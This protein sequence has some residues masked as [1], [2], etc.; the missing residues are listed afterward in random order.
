MPRNA[1]RHASW[2]SWFKLCGV[3]ASAPIQ[4]IWMDADDL[5]QTLI[6]ISRFLHSF[7][8]R[9]Q[10]LALTQHGKVI[11]HQFGRHVKHYRHLAGRHPLLLRQQPMGYV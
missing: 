2:P 1:E 8:K 3:W 7:L 5:Y 9:K 4:P 10:V 6:T 11:A